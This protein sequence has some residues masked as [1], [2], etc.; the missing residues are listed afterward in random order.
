[1]T[2]LVIL[3][4]S[5]RNQKYLIMILNSIELAS[6]ALYLTYESIFYTTGLRTHIIDPCGT[7]YSIIVIKIMHYFIIFA[8]ISDIFLEQGIKYNLYWNKNITK[9]ILILVCCVVN[10]AWMVNLLLSCILLSCK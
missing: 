3:T 2:G 4:R 5:V 1:M 9:I 8:V 7:H 6:F 10:L